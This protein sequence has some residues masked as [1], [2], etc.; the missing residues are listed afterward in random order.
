MDRSVGQL[1]VSLIMMIMIQ[2]FLLSESLY[3]TAEVQS[4]VQGERKQEQK[5]KKPTKKQKQ[6]FVVFLFVCLF[7]FWGEYGPN[8]KRYKDAGS[9][10]SL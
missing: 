4:A 8:T 10:D 6:V 7:V 3:G 5:K 2:L 1:A 9:R